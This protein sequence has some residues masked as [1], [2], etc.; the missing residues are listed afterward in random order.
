MGALTLK[1]FSF[2]LRSWNV[3]SY[4]SIDPTD[5]FGQET[6]VYIQ[7]NQVI[8]IEPQFANNTLSP[9]LTDKG[10]QFFDSIFGKFI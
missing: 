9:W 6:K 8:K 10:R 2:V 5:S 7:K 4:D 3:R 1:S